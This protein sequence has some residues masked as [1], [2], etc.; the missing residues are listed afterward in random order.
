MITTIRRICSLC[1]VLALVAL[2]A[3]CT[4][5]DKSPP[6]AG[7]AAPDMTQIE[8]P[9]TNPVEDMPVYPDGPVWGDAAAEAG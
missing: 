4:S 8:G 5:D 2:S 3:A 1:L 7:D 6:D 9:T